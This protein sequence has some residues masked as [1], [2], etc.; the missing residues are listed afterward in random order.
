MSAPRVLRPFLAALLLVSAVA[1]GTWARPPH[2][3]FSGERHASGIRRLDLDLLDQGRPA[4]VPG[5]LVVRFA[6]GARRSRATRVLDARAAKIKERLPGRGLAVVDLAAGDSVPRA[7]EAFRRDPAV[8]DA[9][10][11]K[12]IYPAGT[13]PNDDKWEE[14]WGLNNTGQEHRIT[15]PPPATMAGTDDADGDVLEAWDKETGTPE[16]VVAVL[17]SGVAVSHSDLDANIWAN[18][19]EIPNNGLDDDGNGFVDD[20]N[21][22]D[23]AEEDKGLLEN[24]ASISGADHGTHVAGTIA[25]EKDNATGVVGVCPECNLMV[26]KFMKPTD[27]NGDNQP[28]TMAG[29]LSAELEALAYARREGADIVNASFTTFLWSQA[30]RRAYKKTGEAGVLTVAAAGNSSL[31]NDMLLSYQFPD[32]SIAFSPEYPA[33]FNLPRI[34]SV[35]ATN[36]NDEYGY[37]TGCATE[38]A[39]WRCEFTSWGHDSVDVGAPGVDIVSTVPGGYDYFNGTSMAAPFTAGV[40]AL[41]ESEHPAYGPMDL[42]NAIMNSVDTPSSLREMPA[43]KQGPAEGRFT[44]TSGRVN[45]DAALNGSTA[46]ATPLTDGNIDG[47]RRM[48]KVKNDRVAWPADTNDVFKRRLRKNKDYKVRL[49]GPAGKDFDLIVWKPGTKEI[50]QLEDGCFLGGAGPCQMLKYLQKRDGS[51]ADEEY[52]FTPKKSG[53]YYFH[54]SAYLFNKGSYTIKVHR[55]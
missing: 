46:N 55:V 1:G 40:A 39:K 43:F 41:V 16:A 27:T 9:E 35:A 49:D 22:W 50:W 31:D 51:R 52:R 53:V 32:G 2:D 29:T 25:A 30:E 54:V 37:F 34:L 26:L 12:L 8:V 15:D 13:A 4:W 47:A 45:A 18:P 10:P 11:N 19:G 42:K 21:G 44:R 5:E 7:L 20:V 36:H 33:S 17:D 3:A 23:F 6:S 14:L 48:R 28:D 38:F 24:D